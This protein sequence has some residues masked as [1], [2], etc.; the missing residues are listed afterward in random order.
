MGDGTPRILAN[1][2]YSILECD[3]N[4]VKEPIHQE[5]TSNKNRWTASKGKAFLTMPAK[6]ESYIHD[7]IIFAEKILKGNPFALST[8]YILF[9]MQNLLQNLI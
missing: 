8:T 6:Q 4:L 3:L 2:L 5:I 7:L 1:I 9:A